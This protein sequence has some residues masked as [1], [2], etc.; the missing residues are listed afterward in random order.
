LF[1]VYGAV[2][3]SDADIVVHLGDYIYEYAIGE[4]GSNPITELLG[5]EHQP[6][7]EIV[8]LDDYRERYRQYRSDPQLQEAHRLKP[9]ICVWDDHEIANDA[10]R[11]G[12]QNHQ[13]SEGD[14][15][16]RKLSALQ[17]WHEYLPARVDDQAKIYRSFDLAGIAHLMMIDTRVIGRDKQLDYNDYL[18]ADGIDA[19]AFLT[20]W[21][22]PERTI[23]GAEQKDWL[24]NQIATSAATWQVLGGQVLMGRYNVPVELLTTIAQL[25]AGNINPNAFEAFQTVMAELAEIKTRILAGDTTVTD[26]E[27]ARVETVFPYNLDGWD[28]YPVERDAI[29][30]SATNKKLIS[31]AGDTH[32]AWHSFLLDSNGNKVGAELAT[33]SVSSPGLE[34]LLGLGPTVKEAFK[35]AVEL[36][37]DDLQFVDVSQRGY[38]MVD[39]SEA[40]VKADWHFIKDLIEK[41]I[42]T[43][44][45]HTAVEA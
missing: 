28:G 14:Y 34:A 29:L 3:A 33:A 16:S 45:E 42:F 4:Y 19:V 26:E 35:N 37:V 6:T 13:E 25:T 32:N 21:L 11:D 40:E 43:A 10:Y 18:T 9:F 15:E 27:R 1:N 17:A 7:G 39:Y 12:A 22:A 8:S 41:D 20:D 38:L 5:R 30:D 36:L 31:L 24:T 23:L 2:A 44:I